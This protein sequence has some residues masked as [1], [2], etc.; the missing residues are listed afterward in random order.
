MFHGLPLAHPARGKLVMVIDDD[1]MVLD[2]MRGVLQSWGCEVQAVASGAAALAE[3]RERGAKP[4]LIISDCR[5]AG[6]KS[7]IEIIERLRQAAAAPIPAFVITGD[8]APERLREASAAGFHLLHKPVSPAALRATLNHFLQDQPRA[9]P[10]GSR[11]PTSTGP[12]TVCFAGF[13]SQPSSTA[14]M[15]ASV[16]L[17]TLSALRTAVTWFLTVGSA[18]SSDAADRLVA[19]ALHHQGQHVDLPVRQ[20]Q[21]ARRLGR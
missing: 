19:L 1:T 4:D 18:R 7:G 10:A 16:R 21:V 17:V 3:F 9:R 5:L 2:G 15:T 20:A 8:T 13:R 14:A 6:G 11:R 12:S